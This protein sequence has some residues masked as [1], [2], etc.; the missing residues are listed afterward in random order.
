MRSPS[1]QKLSTGIYRSTY[2]IRG[3]VNTSVGRKEKRFRLDTPLESIKQ[4]RNETKGKFAALARRRRGSQQRKSRRGTLAFD[5]RR[6]SKTLTIASKKSRASDLKAWV[7]LYGA[8]PRH[9]ITIEQV[10]AAVARW[11]VEE[12]RAWTIQHRLNALRALYKAL[13]GADM[14]TPVDGVEV[15]R[16]ADGHP[17]FVAPKTI[18]LV[19]RRLRRT[20]PDTRARHLALATTGMRPAELMRTLP[21]DI[22]LEH[23]IWPIRTAKGG[24]ARV[25]RLNTPDMLAAA[26]EFIRVHAYGPY[27]TTLHARRL[28]RAGWPDGVRPYATRG[29]W[30]MELSRRG[31]DLADIQYL[32][33]HRDIET[34]RIYYVPAEDSRLAAAT[35]ALEGR[36]ERLKAR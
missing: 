16:P 10:R 32:M 31:V 1:F 12:Y 22:D 4:W 18:T 6:Y 21:G 34:T 35:R 3:V 15:T 5:V 14:P 33:G 25:L 8:W 20:Y 19:A 36:F 30:G 17:V 28:R 29:T 7:K 13:D 11:Q 27:D 2:S 23:G 24:F 26:K 9:R